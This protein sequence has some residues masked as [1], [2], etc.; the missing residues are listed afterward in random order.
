[1]QRQ[2]LETHATPWVAIAAREPEQAHTLL[3]ERIERLRAQV[4]FAPEQRAKVT[5]WPRFVDT[6]PL[7]GTERLQEELAH[8]AA[9]QEYDED[10]AE[11]LAARAPLSLMLA[12]RQLQQVE[13][14]SPGS[15]RAGAHLHR[16]LVEATGCRDLELADPDASDL[17][18]ARQ[19]NRALGHLWRW[20]VDEFARDEPT[21][22]AYR[23]LLDR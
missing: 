2:L 5:E 15:R 23:Q 11:R 18:T 8:L 7:G 9:M 13:W 1:V 4:P 6:M 17:V 20:F 22:R 10:L 3:L 16:F 12:S 21:W 19:Q 14:D